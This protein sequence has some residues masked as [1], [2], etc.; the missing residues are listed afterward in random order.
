MTISGI[1]ADD[2]ELVTNADLRVGD[3]IARVWAPFQDITIR[4]TARQMGN[5]KSHLV[6]VE[7]L[8]PYVAKAGAANTSIAHTMTNI[9]DGLP[10]W[11][12]GLKTANVWIVR[13]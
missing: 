13:R 10:T 12:T 9:N 2:L 8:T 6:T 7:T 5:A 3:V 11:S 1:T 4:P